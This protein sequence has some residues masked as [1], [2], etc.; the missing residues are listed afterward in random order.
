MAPVICMSQALLGPCSLHVDKT[1]H[2]MGGQEQP[3]RSV[4]RLDACCCADL[5]LL[6][7]SKGL[8]D[9]VSQSFR[10]RELGLSSC[11][12]AWTLIRYLAAQSA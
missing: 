5:D 7:R 12:D 6:S 9:S 3:R 1:N 8:T 4:S 10:A 2:G 11:L